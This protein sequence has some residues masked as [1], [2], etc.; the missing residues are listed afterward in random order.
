MAYAE[1]FNE[2]M[3][4]LHTHHP[5]WN[6]EFFVTQFLEG[7]RAE[8]RA[9]VVL[10]RPANL[11][12]AVELACLQEEVLETN[13]KECRKIDSHGKNTL[14]ATSTLA[15][16]FGDS[17]RKG[18]NDRRLKCQLKIK[19]LPFVLT[20]VPKVYVILVE[21]SEVGSI[22]VD[23]QCN[24]M[25]WRNCCNYFPQRMLLNLTPMMLLLMNLKQ[26]NC[27]PF[28]GKQ[29]WALSLLRQCGCKG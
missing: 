26:R 7:L 9:A 10:H 2:L 18:K 25:W 13:L 11:D 4:G 8:I 22:V 15:C 1:N 24:Y 14:R 12:T 6:S 3:H 29:F 27:W 5:S 28:L 23:R 17:G 19:L 16:P 21:R 20:V